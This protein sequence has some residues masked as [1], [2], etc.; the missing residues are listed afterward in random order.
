MLVNI[1]VTNNSP[2]AV[3]SKSVSIQKQNLTS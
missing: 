2:S 1:W 3:I